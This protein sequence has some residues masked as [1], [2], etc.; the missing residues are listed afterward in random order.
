MYIVM[1]RFRIVIGRE[2]TFIDMWQ[3]RESQLETVPGFI[4]FNLLEGESDHNATLFI[5]HSR[6]KS[7]EDFSNWTKSDACRQAHANAG[8][9]RNIYLG[10]TE[11]EAFN[12]VL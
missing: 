2:E 1:N 10:P 9:N 5:S 6:W 12:V 3:E 11:F 8:K 7:A 4:S